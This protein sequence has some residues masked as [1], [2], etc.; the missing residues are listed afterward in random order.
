MLRTL[1]AAAAVLLALLTAAPASADVQVAFLQGEQVAYVDRPGATAADAVRALVAGPTAAERAREITTTVPS[2]TTVAAVSVD[3]A[4][5]ATVDLGQRFA[6]GKRAEIL[7]ARIAQLVLTATQVPGVRSVRVLISGGTP[8]GLFPGYA[9]K[10]PIT[11]AD[12][13][14]EDVPPPTGPPPAPK[15]DPT[16]ATRALQTRLADLGY[17]PRAGVDGK[18]GPQTRFAVLAFQKWEGLARDG[19]AGPATRA[20]LARARRPTPRT[21]ASGRRVEVLLDRQL[22]LYIE[23]GRVV[24]TLHVATGARGFE[25]PTGSFKV[26]RREQRSWSVPYKVWLPWASYFVGGVAFHESPD[27]PAGP[28]SHGCVRVPGYDARWLYERLPNGTPV[29]VLGS[30]R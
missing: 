15:A 17:L 28:A 20:A 21:R 14:D 30:S 3:A 25:T 24:R 19:D 16:A 26:F 23:R 18:A 29:T 8:L 9:T 5:V 1:P 27:V 13:R 7:S 2:G 22:A 4:G 11:A 12:V 10:F 6:R